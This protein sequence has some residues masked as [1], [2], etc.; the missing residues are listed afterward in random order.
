MIDRGIAGDSLPRDEAL[1]ILSAETPL[2]PLLH[3]CGEIRRARFG[4]SV[5]V[6]VLN[7]VQ[8][9]ACPEDCGYCGQAKTS[10]APITAYKLKSREEILDEAAQAKA[11]GAFR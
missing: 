5:Q 6:H 1:R 4:R 3:A 11:S 8:N 9:G 10:D 7:N 2:F